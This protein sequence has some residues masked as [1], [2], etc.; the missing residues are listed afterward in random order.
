MMV[1]GGDATGRTPSDGLSVGELQPSL[2]KILRATG[3][4]DGP[5]QLADAWTAFQRWAATPL[6]SGVAAEVELEGYMVGG[7][8]GV[9]QSFGQPPEFGKDFVAGFEIARK[10]DRG[11]NVGIA[12]NFPADP[13]WR[14]LARDLEWHPDQPFVIERWCREPG[15]YD[16]FVAEIEESPWFQLGLRRRVQV[17]IAF[18]TSVLDDVWLPEGTASRDA[19]SSPD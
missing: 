19:D 15:P 8:R 4:A 11:P 3:P 17:A 10:V 12:L 9:A 13:E 16:D 18:D 1:N 14:K 2:L 6:A 7:T 5:P